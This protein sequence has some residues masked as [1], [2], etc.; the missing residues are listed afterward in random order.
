VPGKKP[1]APA[2][3]TAALLRRRPLPTA[4]ASDGKEE[5][6]TIMVIGGERSTPGA[7][8]LAA[9]AALRAGAGKLQIATAASVAPFLGVA[10]PEALVVSLPETRAGAIHRRAA[11]SLA[12]R[13]AAADAIV[14]GPGMVDAGATAALLAAFFQRLERGPVLVLDAGAVSTLNGSGAL[15]A[16]HEGNLVLTPHA[17]EMASLLDEDKEKVLESPLDIALSAARQYG[18]VSL[19][20]GPETLISRPDGRSWRYTGGDVGLA[21]SGS[22]DVLAGIIAG[23]AARGAD[24]TTAALW[25]VYLH[26]EAGNV[27]AARM[28]RVGFLARE[29]SA[30]LPAL[31]ERTA[32]G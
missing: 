16:R 26:G 25:G 15:L 21:T 32:T 19:L 5:R 30:E 13:A 9:T 8:V 23:L 18:A 17:G 31:L 20:K 12:V 29:L 10:I 22:G 2:A 1:R 3:L 24:A 14:I 28:G 4:A 27:L 11:A 7:V 6:G